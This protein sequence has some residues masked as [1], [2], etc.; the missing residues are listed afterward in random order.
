[1]DQHDWNDPEP[2]FNIIPLNPEPYFS[3]IPPWPSPTEVQ[4]ESHQCM[5][6]MYWT[7]SDKKNYKWIQ[8]PGIILERIGYLKQINIAERP[9]WNPQMAGPPQYTISHISTRNRTIPTAF[10]KFCLLPTKVRRSVWAQAIADDPRVFEMRHPDIHLYDQNQNRVEPHGLVKPRPL[11]QACLESRAE[12]S[13]VD[14]GPEYPYFINFEVDTIYFGPASYWYHNVFWRPPPQNA[15]QVAAY[16][17]D[18]YSKQGWKKRQ[19]YDHWRYGEG[20]HEKGEEQVWDPY[21]NRDQTRHWKDPFHPFL[22]APFYAFERA[23]IKNVAFDLEFWKETQRRRS[24]GQTDL[25]S[26]FP[27]AERFILAVGDIG[28]SMDVKR[29]D[30]GSIIKGS[31]YR[32]LTD[33]Y[34]TAHPAVKYSGQLGLHLGAIQEPLSPGVINMTVD[35]SG[36]YPRPS[37]MYVTRGGKYHG[38][39]RR[40]IGHRLPRCLA[41]I[42][43]D[44][45]NDSDDDH[46]NQEFAWAIMDAEKEEN[47]SKDDLLENKKLPPATEL[48]YLLDQQAAMEELNELEELEELEELRKALNPPGMTAQQTRDT[49]QAF[50]TSAY[51]IADYDNDREEPG[52]ERTEISVV[53]NDSNAGD[54]SKVLAEKKETAAEMDIEPKTDGQVPVRA[55]KKMGAYQHRPLKDPPLQGERVAEITDS[56]LG[57]GVLHYYVRWVNA[58]GTDRLGKYS[59]RRTCAF[60]QSDESQALIATFHLAHPDKPNLDWEKNYE[61]QKHGTVTKKGVKIADASVAAPSFADSSGVSS[62]SQLSAQQQDETN[63]VMDVDQ[64]FVEVSSRESSILSTPPASRSSSPTLQQEQNGEM[65]D[66]IVVDSPSSAQSSAPQQDEEDE[67]EDTVVVDSPAST[68]VSPQQEE[69]FHDSLE[70]QDDENTIV[71]EEPLCTLR[72]PPSILPVSPS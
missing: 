3:T 7:D 48:E 36:T 5:P 1:M 33:K 29:T 62:S 67:M 12:F 38:H 63:D 66:I 65:E 10:P 35:G 47:D 61:R 20:N 70:V 28:E 57:Y 21:Q 46:D 30:E 50:H 53:I 25:M 56:K 71:V 43:E 41:D 72:L 60:F 49:S 14:L 17:G 8:T 59:Y 69:R 23:Q 11:A 51:R 39:P 15:E 58:S 42:N 24:R 6:L 55:E 27:C 9:L 45:D 32:R 16:N 44:D 19:L 31:Y 4:S 68:P 54:G 26:R 34:M 22:S 64:N 2:S 40:L 13:E 18:D 52:E 37:F